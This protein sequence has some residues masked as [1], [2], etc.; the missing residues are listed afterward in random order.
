M[1]N[2]AKNMDHQV[3]HQVVHQG[4]LTR[5]QS[6][7]FAALVQDHDWPFRSRSM[8][9]GDM[10]VVDPEC[11]DLLA[12]QAVGHHVKISTPEALEGAAPSEA[13]A[14]IKRVFVMLRRLER[15][16]VRSLQRRLGTVPVISVTYGAGAA[17]AGLPELRGQLKGRT[18]V[19]ATGGSGLDY[20]SVLMAEN[21]MGTMVDLLPEPEFRWATLMQDFK[22]LRYCLARIQNS[23]TGTA[24]VYCM[25]IEHLEYF[26][27]VT[28]LRYLHL[29]RL[30]ELA[31]ARLIYF[32][33]RDKI[34]QALNLEKK[35]RA[36][37]GQSGGEQSM[38]DIL[39]QILTLTAQ[40]AGFELLVRMMSLV[41]MVTH[42]E[43]VESP[44]EVIKALSQFM[45]YMTPASV[46]VVRAHVERAAGKRSS[47]VRTHLIELLGLKPDTMRAGGPAKQ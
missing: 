35:A 15:T 14:D 2:R 29:K 9:A 21:D 44:V 37:L 11:V 36:A 25:Q 5:E 1:A 4:H 39:D 17:L 47:D 40:E 34:G 16:H 20:L 45:G 27:A 6:D 18:F 22:P 8:V 31:E 26:R 3:A 30:L 12:A 43:L 46:R 19:G 33:R 7:A 24:P 42:E 28:G 41:R 32:T 23:A 10:L 13:I 38:Q